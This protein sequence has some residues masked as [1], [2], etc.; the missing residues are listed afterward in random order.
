[1]CVLHPDSAQ[2]ARVT[3]H[4]IMSEYILTG[5]CTFLISHELWLQHPSGRIC[6]GQALSLTLPQFT[7]EMSTYVGAFPVLRNTKISVQVGSW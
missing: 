4:I 3:H 7:E 2:K 1:M 5:T 6:T